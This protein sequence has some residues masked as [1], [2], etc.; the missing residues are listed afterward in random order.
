[1]AEP[2]F[3]KLILF[4]GPNVISDKRNANWAIIF[5]LFDDFVIIKTYF[6]IGRG[7]EKSYEAVDEIID[8][9]ICIDPKEE[10]KYDLDFSGF[11]SN[12]GIEAKIIDFIGDQIV[13]YLPVV[14]QKALFN[15]AG[16]VLQVFRGQLGNW[17]T[18]KGGKKWFFPTKEAIGKGVARKDINEILKIFNK[19]PDGIKQRIKVI[20]IRNPK[21][22][23]TG[24]IDLFGQ[25]GVSGLKSMMMGR[26]NWRTNTLSIFPETVRRIG[27]QKTLTQKQT[28]QALG[29]KKALERI[30]KGAS[31]EPPPSLTSIMGH[32]VS[33]SLFVPP[34]K[35]VSL[36]HGKLQAKFIKDLIEETTLSAKQVRELVVEK[37]GALLA[38]D[39]KKV[40][41]GKPITQYAGSHAQLLNI[42]A[43]E[44]DKIANTK[45]FGIESKGFNK[46]SDL[47]EFGYGTESFSEINKFY[48]GRKG[49]GKASWNQIQKVFPRTVKTFLEI[50]DV[51]NA[52]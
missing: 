46:L 26:F 29:G 41:G 27:K 17:V 37:P 14:L 2:V 40:V 28:I 36:K 13:V 34:N 3:K 12:F 20:K 24:G 51:T 22:A 19:M 23:R 33:H 10:L 6:A 47:V 8:F 32:E 31:I 5:E 52:R 7:L 43:R 25:P 49:F 38:G 11:S 45:A 1:M 4:D 30:T 44:V 9:D 42:P 35:V 16:K 48:L 15:L 50:L 39:F 21:N 18:L